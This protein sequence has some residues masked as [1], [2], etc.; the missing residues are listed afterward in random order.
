MQNH[1]EQL[2]LL[3]ERRNKKLTWSKA[4]ALLLILIIFVVALYFGYFNI[5]NIFQYRTVDGPSERVEHHDDRD[6][7]PCCEKNSPK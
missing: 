6:K 7:Q 4:I 1:Y 2:P 3:N 5:F